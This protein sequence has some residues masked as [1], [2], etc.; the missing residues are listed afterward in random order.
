MKK[1]FHSIIKTA[2]IASASSASV[3]IRE[4]QYSIKYFY[5]KR[6]QFL[7]HIS[8]ISD[9]KAEKRFLN[10]CALT[11][12]YERMVSIEFLLLTQSLSQSTWSIC[13]D[14]RRSLLEILKYHFIAH[15]VD[16]SEKIL[17]NSSNGIILLL[18]VPSGKIRL[19]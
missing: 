8:G 17:L 5:R 15:F 3:P 1:H 18:K 2:N 4:C 13:Q 16:M 14:R 11:I 7:N 6:L 12:L 9:S 10:F 19:S